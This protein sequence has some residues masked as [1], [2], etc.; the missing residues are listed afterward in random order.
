MVRIE[1]LTEH[2]SIC[3]ACGGE[4]EHAGT[5]TVAFGKEFASYIFAEVGELIEVK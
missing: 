4:L 2:D 5:G 3:I 1:L